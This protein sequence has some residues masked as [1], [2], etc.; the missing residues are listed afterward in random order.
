M[1]KL[2]LS[3][4][5]VFAFSSFANAAL[6]VHVGDAVV[7]SSATSATVELWLS[8]GSGDNFVIGSYNIGLQVVPAT[9]VTVNSFT[10]TSNHTRLFQDNTQIFDLTGN[11]G[12]YNPSYSRYITDDTSPTV[13]LSNGSRDGLFRITYAIAPGT[14]GVFN[15]NLDSSLVEIGD[16]NNPIPVTLDNGSITITPI[17]EPA[18]LG[19]ALLGLPLMMRRRK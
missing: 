18:T 11:I 13:A 4:F 19:L 6:T 7:N 17:P 9:G 2:W 8:Q 12:S 5:A 1:R 15:L 16:G 10:E 3:A 14:T